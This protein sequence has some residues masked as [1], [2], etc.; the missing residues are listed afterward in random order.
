MLLK[1]RKVLIAAFLSVAIL[2]GS[3]VSNSFGL[4]Q[5]FTSPSPIRLPTG[6][7]PDDRPS[8]HQLFNII[9]AAQQG[10]PVEIGIQLSPDESAIILMVLAFLALAYPHLLPERRDSVLSKTAMQ[11]AIRLSK[12]KH[13]QTG[14]P[15]C[16]KHPGYYKDN[17]RYGQ[18]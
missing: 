9:P 8:Y 10:V 12:H 14:V 6:I 17:V 15:V 4:G 5:V 16:Q 11:G 18:G 3:I 13:K 2:V 1:A 7:E